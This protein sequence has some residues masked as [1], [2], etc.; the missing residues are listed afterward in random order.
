MAYLQLSGSEAVIV[1]CVVGALPYCIMLHLFR[2]HMA[3]K[4]SGT[5]SQK[6]TVEKLGV[7]L[8]VCVLLSMS[9]TFAA[10]V[11]RAYY[12]RAR[13]SSTRSAT[14]VT[15]TTPTPLVERSAR[16]D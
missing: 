16:E 13:P 9:A 2:E 3:R 1:F 6:D 10:C 11:Y 7:Y 8:F 15:D 4:I 14:L 5:E 12:K